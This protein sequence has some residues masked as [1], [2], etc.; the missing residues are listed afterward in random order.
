MKTRR[1]FLNESFTTISGF[2]VA[3]AFTALGERLKFESAN[4]KLEL[5]PTKDQTTGI[6]LIHLPEGFRYSTFGWTGRSNVG[7]AGYTSC[8]RWNGG[9]G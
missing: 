7:R 4:T 2:G 3:A 5:R 6:P 8:A 1:E 9:C